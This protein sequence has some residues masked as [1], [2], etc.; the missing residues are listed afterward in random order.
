[1]AQESFDQLLNAVKQ[2][3]SRGQRYD[4]SGQLTT[5]PKGAQ[6]EMQVM[7]KTALKPGHGVLPA[8][9]K[10]PYRWSGCTDFHKV[11]V[12]PI[13]CTYP[14]RSYYTRHLA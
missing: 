6:G 11:V 2:A 9:D 13:G 7:P 8:Q 10:S 1:M 5:S 4:K 12:L 3:E 14:P